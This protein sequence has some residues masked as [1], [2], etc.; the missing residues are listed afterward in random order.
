MGVY[1]TA[2]LNSEEMEPQWNSRS[3]AH[4]SLL[5]YTTL[6]ED[7][8]RSV[9]SSGNRRKAS[10][11][12]WVTNI[13]MQCSI[14]FQ[15]WPLSLI[16][17]IHTIKSWG[18]LFLNL[19]WLCDTLTNRIWQVWHRVSSRSN[20]DEASTVFSLLGASLHDVK[21]LRPENWNMRQ[22]MRIERTSPLNEAFLYL[23][24]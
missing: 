4:C 15:S 13:E 12:L 16:S 22:H 10:L 6:P 8:Q 24:D 23:P 1:Y 18:P 19:S 11:G 20:F 2:L 21:K 14:C 17:W 7:V 3:V 9:N 5:V